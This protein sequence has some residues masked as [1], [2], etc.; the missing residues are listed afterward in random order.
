MYCAAFQLSGE[1]LAANGYQG[2]GLP[3][4]VQLKTQEVETSGSLN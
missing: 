1:R 3:D 2:N 4:K